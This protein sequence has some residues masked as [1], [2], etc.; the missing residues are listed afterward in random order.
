M[1]KWTRT[2][3]GL[4]AHDDERVVEHAPHDVVAGAGDLRLVG[5]EHPRRAE[6]PVALE[7]E[8]LGVAVHVRRD[9]PRADRRGD[10]VESITAPSTPRPA[11]SRRCSWWRQSR[12][13]LNAEPRSGS[14]ARSAAGSARRRAAELRRRGTPSGPASRRRG[15]GRRPARSIAPVVVSPW[16]RS[17]HTGRPSIA[18]TISSAELVGVDQHATRVH[19]DAARG[20]CARPGCCTRR[21]SARG[22]CRRGRRRRRPAGG[23]GRRRRPPGRRG[24]RRGG[25]AARSVARTSA[26]SAIACAGP[27]EYGRT[28]SGVVNSSPRSS[29]PRE[30]TRIVS[31]ST[32]TLMWP[33]TSSQSPALARIRHPTAIATAQRRADTGRV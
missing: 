6:Q 32:R 20:E 26:P 17:T 9:H 4:V 23:R 11:S 14:C 18:A 21:P 16:P 3:A 15:P 8:D 12:S 1:L 28:S 31:S 10:V 24:S 27:S 7:L 25:S 29:G 19:G 30:R 33:R 5:E 22:R 2:V 13:S